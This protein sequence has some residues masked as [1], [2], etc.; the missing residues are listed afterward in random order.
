[1][2]SLGPLDA[3]GAT[4]GCLL[5]VGAAVVLHWCF[6]ERDLVY[7]QAALVAVGAVGGLLIEHWVV[8]RPPK[9]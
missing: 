4:L 9:H 2:N 3:P 8:D 7:L 5:G 1:M 6:P